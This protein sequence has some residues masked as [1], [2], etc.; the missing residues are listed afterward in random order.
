MSSKHFYSATGGVGGGAN[1]MKQNLVQSGNAINS[2]HEIIVDHHQPSSSNS[3][4]PILH[5]QNSDILMVDD[6]T[7]LYSKRMNKQQQQQPKVIATKSFRIH[8]QTSAEAPAPY[9]YMDQSHRATKPASRYHWHQACKISSTCEPSATELLV[10]RDENM[11]QEMCNEDVY[12]L[13]LTQPVFADGGHINQGFEMISHADIRPTTPVCYEQVEEI[14][15][16]L[17]KNN[18]N[19]K[20]QPPPPC[21][22]FPQEID[23]KSLILSLKHQHP[24]LCSQG[25]KG[26][27]WNIILN[28]CRPM[29]SKFF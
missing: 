17:N 8:N 27:I 10:D 23:C 5:N 15:T 13:R 25:K 11:R 21:H 12:T 6:I 19:N 24:D 4:R 7:S 29:I 28:V 14:A 20:P 1:S 18:Y 9:Q 16:S 26:I 22:N 2:R 3:S